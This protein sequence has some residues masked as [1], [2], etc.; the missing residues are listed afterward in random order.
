MPPIPLRSK[1]GSSGSGSDRC[2]V[3]ALTGS[4]LVWRC[5][6]SRNLSRAGSRPAPDISRLFPR[7]DPRRARFFS[8]HLRDQGCGGVV[9]GFDRPDHLCHHPYPDDAPVRRADFWFVRRSLWAATIPVATDHCIG[10]CRTRPD[11]R[12][13]PVQNRSIVRWRHGRKGRSIH[14]SSLQTQAT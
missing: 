5:G 1:S 3:D 4:P 6:S 12:R 10:R 2:R 11:R 13:Q 9:F 8:P 14:R 7:L